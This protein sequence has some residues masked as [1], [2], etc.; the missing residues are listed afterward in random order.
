MKKTATLREFSYQ[1]VR[2]PRGS[3]LICKSWQQEGALRMLQNNLD[4]DVAEKPE[5]LIVYGGSG[6][7]ARN[8]ECYKKIVES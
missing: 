1:P 5:E 4:P 2:A 3:K 6:R 8:W 7:A